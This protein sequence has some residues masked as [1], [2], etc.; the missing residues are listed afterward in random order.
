M[1]EFPTLISQLFS[2]LI[3]ETVTAEGAES[4]SL[5]TSV[6]DVGQKVTFHSRG[7]NLTVFGN[8][9]DQTFDEFPTAE[10]TFKEIGAY[11]LEHTLLGEKGTYSEFVYIKIASKHSDIWR[12]VDVLNA[13]QLLT[14]KEP[15]DDDLLMYFA[16]ALVFLL[17]AEWWLQAREQ[18]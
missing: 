14:K 13:P 3:P 16:A 4:V 9:V 15:Q 18:F 8:G 7:Q 2:Y 10:F 12:T 1:W 6:F 11:T 17:F 5:R